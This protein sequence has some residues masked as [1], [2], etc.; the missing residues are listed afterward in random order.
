MA[1]TVVSRPLASSATSSDAIPSWAVV[2]TKHPWAIEKNR[3][4]MAEANA[5]GVPLDFVL[6]GDSITWYHSFQTP[7]SFNKYF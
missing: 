1:S 4:V 3:K 6:Y 2:S 7:D 5:K